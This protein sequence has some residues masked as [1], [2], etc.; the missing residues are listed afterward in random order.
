[1]TS[2]EQGSFVTLCVAFAGA[3]GYLLGIFSMRHVMRDMVQSVL[4]LKKSALIYLDALL[5]ISRGK[6]NSISPQCLACEAIQ[7]VGAAAR[8]FVKQ[9]P[10]MLPPSKLP[11]KSIK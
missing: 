10:H 11:V 3:L 7:D 2:A 8:I 9:H 5:V 4:F 6:N 1:M